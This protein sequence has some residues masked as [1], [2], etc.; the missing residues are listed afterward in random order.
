VK[1]SVALAK[2]A[3]L[4]H[5]GWLVFKYPSGGF[6]T[7]KAGWFQRNT[8][9]IFWTTADCQLV[10]QSLPAQ[11]TRLAGQLDQRRQPVDQPPEDR[12]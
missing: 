8:Q 12:L 3:G 9:P 1:F 11:L 10:D 6:S 7:V 5:C 4:K 2:L